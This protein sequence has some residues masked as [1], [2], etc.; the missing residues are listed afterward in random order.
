MVFERVVIVLSTGRCSELDIFVPNKIC[1]FRAHFGALLVV[2]GSRAVLDI[3]EV[4]GRA[5]GRTR[6]LQKTRF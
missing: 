5:S 2:D 1:G 6:C 3:L 4:T